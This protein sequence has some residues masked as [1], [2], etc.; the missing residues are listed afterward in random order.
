MVH[1]P[2]DMLL[3][4]HNKG[5][6]MSDEEKLNLFIKQLLKNAKEQ[7]YYPSQLM[8]MIAR[9][10]GDQ[11]KAISKLVKSTNIQTGF[12]RLKELGLLDWSVESAVLKFPSLFTK[13]EQVYAEF[14]LSEARK[15]KSTLSE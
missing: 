7:D 9:E 3:V 15:E 8:I 10:N 5:N 12:S 13:E 11:A 14:R 1:F 4:H 6:V 2:C